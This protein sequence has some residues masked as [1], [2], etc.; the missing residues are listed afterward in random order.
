[1]GQ[2]TTPTVVGER[3]TLR[4]FTE[5]DVALVA[6]VVDDPLIPLISTVP[7]Q[8]DRSQIFAYIE[9]Q[10]GRAISG[11]G[12]Q[13]TVVDKA[14]DEPVGQVGLTFR[15]PMLERASVGY[16]IA[17]DRR[18]AGFATAAIQ[19]LV[20]WAF[21]HLPIQR[22]E[23]YVEPWNEGSWRAAEAAGFQREGLL[24]QWEHVG[25]ERKDMYMYALLREPG[26]R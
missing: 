9:R 10:R 8:G 5:R 26:M 1:M 19:V 6:S 7:A 3:V 13:F 15:E 16:W 24:R 22:L 23:L 18:G 14:T 11:A 2:R 4:D 12:Y 20:G 21:A 25:S 17:P